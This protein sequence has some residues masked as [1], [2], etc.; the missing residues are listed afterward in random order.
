MTKRR[1]RKG[2][3]KTLIGYEKK[4]DVFIALEAWLFGQSNSFDWLLWEKAK[5]RAIESRSWKNH[6]LCIELEHVACA[7]L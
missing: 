5:S 7:M 3:S 4:G 6:Q 2:T 1:G